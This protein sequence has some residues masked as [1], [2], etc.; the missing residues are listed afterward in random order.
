MNSALF[1][2]NTRKIKLNGKVAARHHHGF[3]FSG[4]GVKRVECHGAFDLGNDAG[5]TA[6]RCL[7]AAG[8]CAAQAG[9]IGGCLHKRQRNEIGTVSH[10]PVGQDT[11]ARSRCGQAD[12]SL[13]KIDAFAAGDDA[14]NFAHALHHAAATRTHA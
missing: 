11:I 10:R 5:D 3:R 13:W 12:G 8:K 14:A 7:C 4:D 1:N 6:A 2:W 9:D